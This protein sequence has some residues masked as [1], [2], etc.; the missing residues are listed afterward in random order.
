MDA[1]LRALTVYVLLA[2][3][4]RIAGKRTL[5]QITTFDF[6]LVLVLGEATQQALLGDDPSLTNAT[7]VIVTLVTLDIAFSWLK[8]HYPRVECWVDGVPIVLVDRGQL[9]RERM[10]E[11]RIDEDDVLTAAREA[12]GLEHLDEIKFAVLERGGRI[13][14]VPWRHG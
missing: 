2:L 1:I 12:H 13:S 6:V 5:A 9:L 7:L 10:R 3:V 8:V 11:A 14:I 4:F